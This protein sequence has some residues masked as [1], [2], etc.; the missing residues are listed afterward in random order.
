MIEV[1][2]N[3]IICNVVLNN[4]D[5]LQIFVNDDKSLL[6]IFRNE[7]FEIPILELVSDDINEIITILSRRKN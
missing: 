7:D 2:C 6:Q 4:N 1:E 5:T 3:N